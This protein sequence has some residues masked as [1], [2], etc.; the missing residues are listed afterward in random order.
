MPVML[1]TI[2]LPPEVEKLYEESKLIAAKLAAQALPNRSPQ[3]F[4]AGSDLVE[5]CPDTMVIIEKGVYK[6]FHGKR[7]VRFYSNADLVSVPGAD[8]GKQRRIVTE[9][10]SQVSIVSKQE[11]QESIRD[12]AEAA[13]LYFQFC[14]LESEI[15][16]SLCAA[17][18]TD[19]SRPEIECR[20]FSESDVIIR[21]A[22][23]AG[24]VFQLIEGK[25]VASRGGVG[26]GEIK[27]GE[28]FGEVS[29]LAA[30]PRSATVTAQT[31]CIVQ[32]MRESDFIHLTKQRPRTVLEMAKVLATRLV[33]VNSRLA[34]ESA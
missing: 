21:E 24:E 22:E 33:E 1:A 18:I 12:A 2:E 7:M 10:G 31:R 30:K 17:S 9:F 19:D 4:A 29:F 32:I 14:R 26:I 13:D 15:L 5:K 8:A 3:V 23:T 20:E 16:S 6:S 11:F 28:I 27:A 34:G 25:A